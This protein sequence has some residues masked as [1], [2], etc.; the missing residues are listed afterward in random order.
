[1]AGGPSQEFCGRELVRGDVKGLK[2]NRIIRS[3]CPVSSLNEALLRLI[4]GRVSKRTIV[5]RTGDKPSLDDWCVLAHLMKQRVYGVWGC[6]RA[7]ADW[8]DNTVAR[9]H[10]QLIY[11]DAGRAFTELS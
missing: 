6:G 4:K 5:I 8:E 7:Q 3:P 2:W 10:V 11:E 1:M 9:R